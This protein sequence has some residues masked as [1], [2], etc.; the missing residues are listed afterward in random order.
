MTD[1]QRNNPTF[2]SGHEEKF[3]AKTVRYCVKRWTSAIEALS[4]GHTNTCAALLREV[5]ESQARAVECGLLARLAA[6]RTTADAEVLHAPD[7]DFNRLFVLSNDYT[8]SSV[9][10]ELLR[11]FGFNFTMQSGMPEYQPKH[12]ERKIK[13]KRPDPAEISREKATEARA[14]A[15]S[16]RADIDKSKLSGDLREAIKALNERKVRSEQLRTRVKQ[17]GFYPQAG[18]F[19]NIGES[20]GRGAS[21]ALRDEAKSNAEAMLGATADV[22]REGASNK[23]DEIIRTVKKTFDSTVELMMQ[24]FGCSGPSGSAVRGF[25]LKAIPVVV[26]FALGHFSGVNAFLFTKVAEFFGVSLGEFSPQFGEKGETESIGKLM[27]AAAL[28][29]IVP[30]FGMTTKAWAPTVALLTKATPFSSG[31]KSIVDWILEAIQWVVNMFLRLFGQG[32]IH[33]FRKRALQIDEWLKKSHDYLAAPSG[34]RPDPVDVLRHWEEGHDLAKTSIGSVVKHEIDTMLRSLAT[35]WHF[36]SNARELMKAAR[37]EPLC[38]VLH[39]EPGIG[40]SILMDNLHSSITLRTDPTI[41]D[42]VLKA[43]EDGVRYPMSKHAYTKDKDR[44]WSGYDPALHTTMMVDDGGTVLPVAGQL[45]SDFLMLM[46]IINSAPTA[47]E[48]AIAEDKG[49]VFFRSSLVLI[50]TNLSEVQ[51]HTYAERAISNPD[52][53]IRRLQLFLTMTIADAT[54]K[55]EDGKLDVAAYHRATPEARDRAFTFQG[56]YRGARHTF[57][58]VSDLANFASRHMLAAKEHFLHM[59]DVAYTDALEFLGG[60]EPQ[61]GFADGLKTLTTVGLSYLE[62]AR[63]RLQ[64]VYKAI[65]ALVEWCSEHTAAAWAAIA[66]AVAAAL[67]LAIKAIRGIV[68]FVSSLFLKKKKDYSPQAQDPGPYFD[69]VTR[70]MYALSIRQQHKQDPVQVFGAIL[71]VEGNF[72][73]MPYHFL[74]NMSQYKSDPKYSGSVPTMRSMAT[75][76]WID[77]EWSLF[78]CNGANVHQLTSDD[79]MPLD[80]AVVRLAGQPHK[81]ITGYMLPRSVRKPLD[82][83]WVGLNDRICPDHSTLDIQKYVRDFRYKGYNLSDAVLY[84]KNTRAGDCGSIV[85][86]MGECGR[87]YIVGM[88]T[89]GDDAG[90][91]GVAGVFYKDQIEMAMK[92]ISVRV[93]TTTSVTLSSTTMDG[94]EPH[95]GPLDSLSYALTTYRNGKPDGPADPPSM[96]ECPDLIG[97]AN[98]VCP[99]TKVPANCSEAATAQAL[100]AYTHPRIFPDGHRFGTVA[101]M[102]ASCMLKDVGMPS[103]LNDRVLTFTEAVTGLAHGVRFAEPINHRTS[104]GYPWQSMGMTKTDMFDELGNLQHVHPTTLA[105]KAEVE[106][107]MSSLI[108]GDSTFLN[109]ILFKVSPKRELRPPTKPPRIIQGAPIHLVVVFRMLFWSMMAHFAD[110][111]PE[112]EL[113]I[114]LD[115]YRHWTKL[116]EWVT[117]VQDQGEKG[118]LAVGVDKVGAGDYSKFDQCHEPVISGGIGRAV[119]DRYP[120]SVFKKARELLWPTLCGPSI[121]FKNVAY[122]LPKGLPSGHPATSVVNGLY[123]GTLFRMAFASQQVNGTLADAFPCSDNTVLHHLSSFRKYVRLSVCGDDNIFGTSVWQFNE[124]ALSE[125]MSRFGATYTM[126]QK[127]QSATQFFRDIREVSYLGRGF[128]FESMTLEWAAPLRLESVAMMGQYSEKLNQQLDPVWGESIAK[129]VFQELALHDQ[130][131]WEKWMPHAISAFSFRPRQGGGMRGWVEPPPFAPTAVCRVLQQ[132]TKSEWARSDVLE[133]SE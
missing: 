31:C 102:A 123:N 95:A 87:V 61:G 1:T 34:D 25:L 24:T 2:V 20:I 46:R 82:L 113:A 17:Q 16:R 127:D 79:G 77:L 8:T 52:A 126:D 70:N 21:R 85:I 106:F 72:A 104:T 35:Q 55:K 92:A 64:P 81:R 3:C 83:G 94:F 90:G 39:G 112:K 132:P 103:V 89:A 107:L 91:T 120:D 122:K 74:V 101:Y 88:H 119:L 97:W 110:W 131:T 32:E 99:L 114:G 69:S 108:R 4:R 71:M 18:L 128:R 75:G 45:D 73:V 58:R 42:K 51:W 50:S 40:K 62:L 53:L 10:V 59:Q 47:L 5:E 30:L 33:W 96:V 124:M 133:S 86:S 43:Q 60:F 9:R 80:L 57:D 109:A 78:S 12:K 68:G 7:I 36:A 98:D 15:A 44:F 28:G 6:F 111:A 27:F 23:F 41:R 14:K 93:N 115:P 66:T 84:S 100:V 76:Q 37:P 116:K 121:V 117:G 29:A 125:I 65:E 130:Q 49:S 19:E 48:S 67:P 56:T 54:M 118:S 22:L 38:I 105:V 129:Q 13:V 63:D 11:A 26:I